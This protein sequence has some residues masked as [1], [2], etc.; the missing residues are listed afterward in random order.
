ME[1]FLGIARVLI[2]DFVEL[3]G[4]V[5]ALR[6]PVDGGVRPCLR[7]Y[8][9]ATIEWFPFLDGFFGARFTIGKII[10]F[11]ARND[12]RRVLGANL[13]KT[14]QRMFDRAFF[15]YRILGRLVVIPAS[16]ILDR[17]RLERLL[18]DHLL[19]IK[20]F[21]DAAFR[22]VLIAKQLFLLVD[23]CVH[24]KTH[25]LEYFSHEQGLA[26]CT[27]HGLRVDASEVRVSCKMSVDFKFL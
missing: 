8:Q 27:C 17:L 14:Y 26:C 24:R 19:M 1:Q 5:V 22:A 13:R 10:L 2:G 4:E 6:D 18:S 16:R 15:I 3:G 7:A 11:L 21:I 9:H 25:L 20:K 12:V 23:A